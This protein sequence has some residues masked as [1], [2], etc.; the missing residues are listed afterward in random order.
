MSTASSVA[1]GPVTSPTPLRAIYALVQTAVQDT[2]PV[3]AA[4]AAL[5]E[6]ASGPAAR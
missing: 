5:D 4:L 6:C 3:R 1:A 2:A